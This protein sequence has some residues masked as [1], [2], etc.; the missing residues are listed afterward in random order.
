MRQG[1]DCEYDKRNRSVV[2]WDTEINWETYT[3]YAGAAEMLL[4]IMERSQWSH[5]VCRN[6]S[7]L[8]IPTDDFEVYDKGQ[9][10]KEF[11]IDLHRVFELWFPIPI[12]LTAT[13]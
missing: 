1:P 6:I 8:T 12:K 9:G 2:S 10:M 5:L 3:P 11:V 4:H 7:F 13:I